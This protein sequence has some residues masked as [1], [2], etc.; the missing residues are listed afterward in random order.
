MKKISDL[1]LQCETVEE[2]EYLK[3]YI[4]SETI[5]CSILQHKIVRDYFK[6]DQ[7]RVCMSEDPY[8][9]YAEKLVMLPL[10]GWSVYFM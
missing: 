9:K 8:W 6:L 10:S 5:L 1:I 7:V 2:E 4:A 3:D